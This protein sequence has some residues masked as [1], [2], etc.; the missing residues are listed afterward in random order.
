[1]KNT[2]IPLAAVAALVIA[3]YACA[4][5]PGV[6]ESLSRNAADSYYNLLVQ[7]F[8]AGH[9]SLNKDVPPGLA[10]L[11]DPY[12][13]IANAPYR[14]APYRLHDLTYYKGRF[15]L[16]WGVTPALL[17]FWP[18]VALTGRYLFHSQAVTIFCAIGFLASVGLLR[19][20]WRR[21][22]AEVSVGVVAACALALGLATGVPVML[23]RADVY[24]I[25]I[26]C[27]YML[28]MLTL[29]AIWCALHEPERRCRWL[30]AASIAYGLAVGAR[31]SLLFGAIILLVPVIQTW[32]EQRRVWAVLLAGIIPIGLIGLGL[33]LYNAGRFDSPFEFGAHYQVTG[34]RQVTLQLF[35]PRYFWFN[36]RVYFLEPARWSALFP[37]VHDIAVPPL[38][39]GY[40]LVERPFGV[41]LNIPLVWLALAVPLAWRNR[42]G[43]ADS[44]L[45]SFVTTVALLFGMDALTLVFFYSSCLRYEVDF[46][47]ALVL[48][49]AIGILNVERAL[50]PTPRSGLADHPARRRAARWGWGLLLV[51]SVAFNLF[52]NIE[53]SI[54]NRHNL[55]TAL[56]ED[57]RLTEAVQLYEQTLRIAPYLSAAHYN[58]GVA[59]A[60]L[61]RQQ[62]AM[63]QWEQALQIDPD[64]AEAHYNLGLALSQAGRIPQ[65]IA[66]YEQALRIKPDFT[67]ARTALAH[68]QAG[69]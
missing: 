62:E 19:A 5:H 56:I 38:P 59:L 44:P 14:V 18:A 67:E 12:D 39:A 1:M 23:S 13:P 25:P 27:G 35:S 43:T 36:F 9:L 60:R 6:R 47:P 49:A 58:L 63:A 2:W 3:V 45:R 42:P 31:P 20:L 34:G 7:G 51:F 69:Q 29:A 40:G 57:G 28:T 50:A 15:Y 54:E 41:L 68:L 21:Y 22:F 8:R 33:M 24:E 4:T 26:S 55:G 37:F 10:Q 53:N 48:L 65:A 64:D 61:G 11:A 32:R 52:A 16:Y 30:A 17:L 66:H 46:L